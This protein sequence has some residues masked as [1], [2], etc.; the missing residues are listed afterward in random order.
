MVV[1]CN[2]PA[3]STSLETESKN[4]VTLA[5][6]DV[7]EATDAICSVM[8][9]DAFVDCACFYMAPN[10]GD[11]LPDLA[12]EVHAAGIA[13]IRVRLDLVWA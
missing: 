3:E 6:V 9:I 8:P 10:E 2:F 12:K 13:A 4:L 11:D 5:G 1:D 7:V